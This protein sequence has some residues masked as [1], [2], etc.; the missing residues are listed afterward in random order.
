MSDSPP[1]PRFAN[2]RVLPL[3]Q[4]QKDAMKLLTPAQLREGI[5]LV[6]LLR[7][8]PDT[9][10]L[11]ISP[12]GRG[13][14]LRIEGT[15]INPQGWLRAIVW[16][17]EPSKTIYVVDLFWKKTNQITRADLHRANHRIRQLNTLVGAGRNPWRRSGQ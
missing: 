15:T 1:A 5:Q 14:E 17:H 2:Y 13:L 12:C 8:Y 6:R 9:P 10:D 7:L 16:V 3:P 4:V 11:S